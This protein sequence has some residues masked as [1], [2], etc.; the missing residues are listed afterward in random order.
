MASNDGLHLVFPC[1]WEYRIIG[2][3]PAAI[4]TTV[5]E[6][7][8]ERKVE[9]REGRKSRNGKYATIHVQTVIFNHEERLELYESLQR[10]S[11][12]KFIL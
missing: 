2:E 9:L 8:G 10:H 11:S 5:R 7:F 12:I 1:C 3:D 4:E 6:V